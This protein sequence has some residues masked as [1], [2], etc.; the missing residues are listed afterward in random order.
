MIQN[1]YEMN[2][3]AKKIAQN[4]RRLMEHHQDTQHSLAAKSGISQRTIG[5]ILN[6]GDEKAC[7]VDAIEAIAKAYNIPAW[8][9]LLPNAPIVLLKDHTLENFIENYILFDDQTKR[10]VDEQIN[11]LAR[12]SK[13]SK[14]T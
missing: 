2:K 12:L 3:E 4:L 13:I 5:N 9:F 1:I 6:P 14:S 7:G 8:K 10:S 11:N